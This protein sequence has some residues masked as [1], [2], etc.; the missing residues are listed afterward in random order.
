MLAVYLKTSELDIIITFY[1]DNNIKFFTYLFNQHFE[2]CFYF[3]ILKYLSSVSWTNYKMIIVTMHQ[4]F[5]KNHKKYSKKLPILWILKAPQTL[6]F[7]VILRIQ[8]H[9]HPI[10]KGD[11][12]SRSE[13]AIKRKPP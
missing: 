2:T 13:R 6:R 4:L 11:G 5:S 7:S 1:C 3:C 10:S 9:F 12:L 8:P